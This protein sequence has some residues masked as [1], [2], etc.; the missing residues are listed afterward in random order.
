[1]A[2]NY[3]GFGNSIGG[4]SGN[5]IQ[6]MLTSVA[7][8]MP[9]S[10]EK[11]TQNV[12]NHIQQALGQLTQLYSGGVGGFKGNEQ[13]MDKFH[14]PNAFEAWNSFSS[15]F[16]KKEKLA[17][18][19]A[20]V[21]ALS[22]KQRY[23]AQKGMIM[24]GIDSNLKNYQ[25][26]NKLS[27]GN[28]RAKMSKTP[29][30]ASFITENT[31]DPAVSNVST[32]SR[33]WIDQIGGVAKA[34]VPAPVLFGMEQDTLGE[35]ASKVAGYGAAYKYGPKGIAAAKEYF[36]MK[37]S[38]AKKII[39]VVKSSGPTGQQLNLFGPSGAP[40][41]T[42]ILKSLTSKMGKSQ[43]LKLLAKLPKNPY[44]IAAALLGM[45]IYSLVKNKDSYQ[46]SVNNRVSSTYGGGPVNTQQANPAEAFKTAM[47]TYK[48][49]NNL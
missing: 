45:G 35:A 9:N 30:I 13:Y 28:M 11:M 25:N 23:D 16:S 15:G 33:T 4:G 12:E 46:D 34:I 8:G 36:G 29:N 19:R 42:S 20:G 3:Q 5:K 21:N 41:K 24:Q 14:F 38:A 44:V 32:P 1:M 2:I 43:A 7:Q 18:Q 6:E 27:D 26:M 10:Q 17:A 39:D 48:K 22:F 40:T 31:L 37:P 47:A 49:N